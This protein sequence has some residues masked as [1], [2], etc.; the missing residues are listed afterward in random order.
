[1]K[2]IVL[3]MF[4]SISLLVASEGFISYKVDGKEYEGYYSTPSKDAPLVYIVHDWDG[5]TDYEIKRAKMLY[6]LGYASFAVDLYG[7]GIRPTALEDKKRLTS[8]LYQDREKMRSL[9]DAGLEL[10]KSQG[11]NISNAV[12]IG[13]CFGGAAIL[14]M[15]RSGANLKSFISFH[16]GLATPKGQ[17]YSKLKGSVFV[18]HGGADKVVPISDFASLVTQLEDVKAQYEMTVYSGAPHAFSV[19]G[20]NRYHKKADEESWARFTEIL[21]NTLK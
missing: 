10:A 11:A 7:K 5:L 1:M 14:E 8:E 4:V 9:L 2:K 16:G 12:G 6:D 20:S 18:F 13:Y 3:F 21:A 17:D 19:I 15:A